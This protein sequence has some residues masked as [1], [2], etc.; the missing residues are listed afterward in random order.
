VSLL[1]GIGYDD[2]IYNHTYNELTQYGNNNITNDTNKQDDYTHKELLSINHIYSLEDSSLLWDSTFNAYNQSYL[3]H[4]D[5]DINLLALKS[6]PSYRN[7]NYR[8]YFPLSIEKIWYG[9]ESFLHIYGL[10]PKFKML[11]NQTLSFD[12]ET[13]FYKKEYQQYVDKSKNSSIKEISASLNKLM[14]GT[15]LL[16]FQTKF[17]A[18]RKNSLGRIDISRDLTSGRLTY[19]HKLNENINISSYVGYE[20]YDYKD[21][22]TI[23]KRRRDNLV[24]ASVN[25]YKKLTPT[26]S[27]EFNFTH[28]ENDSN[29]N[30]YSYKK[31]TF[32]TNVLMKF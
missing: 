31:N 32:F 10:A 8:L 2:N 6:G 29:I 27:L 28:L 17:S 21:K 16:S 24:R 4:H 19:F 12:L 15:D 18:E 22:D 9:S 26:I 30:L 1:A 13:K 14:F 20:H 3:N 5:S 23:L 7:K 11:I 25:L